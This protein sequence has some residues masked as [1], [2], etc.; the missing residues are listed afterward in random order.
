MSD[1]KNI[2]FNDLPTGWV[3]S[4]LGE[5]VAKRARGIVPDKTPDETF[6]LYSVPSHENRRPEIVQ[7]KEIGSN[8][9]LVEEG[10]V[11]LCKINP[12]INR[13]WVVGNH[14][15]HQRIA[16]TEWITFPP[17]DMFEPR[18]LAYYMRQDTFRE[19]LAGNASGV[20]G[21]LMRVKPATITDYP[22]PIAPV[23]HQT[24][25]VA[26]IEKQFSRL[27]EA[28]ANL[29]RVK[30]N[31]KRYK[32]AVLKAA[33]EGKLTE[34]WRKKNPD[35]EPADKLLERI[36]AERRDKWQGRGKYKEPVAPD[37]SGLPKLP[38]GWVWASVEQLTRFVT[39][40]SRGWGGSYSETGPLFI[41]AQD[42][43]TEN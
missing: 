22:F 17:C 20:G 5:H 43:K 9:Q 27:D 13:T 1:L 40:G 14:S 25:I 6:E 38:E 21:S 3:L 39:S 18:Y 15:S 11:L 12:R 19:F 16:S 26:E 35:V 2:V 42:I 34:E 32:A 29:K 31:L 28:V 33:V 36:L 7:G 24:R 8:K 23:E 10:T 37:A 4:T 30:A 41:R